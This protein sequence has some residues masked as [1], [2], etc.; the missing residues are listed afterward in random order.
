M[1]TYC[2][3]VTF[4]TIVKLVK[5]HASG[6]VENKEYLGRGVLRTPT[7][8]LE[9]AIDGVHLTSCSVYDSVDFI[10]DYV[11]HFYSFHI[12]ISWVCVIVAVLVWWAFSNLSCLAN[13]LSSS[14]INIVVPGLLL[15]MVCSF[16]AFYVIWRGT[17]I[18]CWWFYTGLGA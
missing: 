3:L 12:W 7:L 1:I 17:A 11:R 2:I 4:R 8:C 16:Y 15:T 6:F 14:C 5:S 18:T 9:Q 13:L 10:V